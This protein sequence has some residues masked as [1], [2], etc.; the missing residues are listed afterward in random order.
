MLYQVPNNIVGMPLFN[1]IIRGVPTAG[2]GIGHPDYSGVYVLSV[3]GEIERFC[4]SE[5]PQNK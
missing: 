4:S 5:E 3:L 1:T 2:H